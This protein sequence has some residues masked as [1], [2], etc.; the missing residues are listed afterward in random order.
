M[1]VCSLSNVAS[2]CRGRS[3]RVC[4]GFALIYTALHLHCICTAFALHFHFISTAFA[5]HLHCIC[6]VFALQYINLR[7]V[8]FALRIPNTAPLKSGIFCTTLQL[9]IC[10]IFHLTPQDCLTLQKTTLH[11]FALATM[12]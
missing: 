7:C 12:H 5:L 2:D 8:T 6:T 1:H 11:N 9:E 4:C 3:S 10:K